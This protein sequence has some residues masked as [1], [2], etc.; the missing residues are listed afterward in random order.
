M[1]EDRKFIHVRVRAADHELF[2]A[3]ARKDRRKLSDWVRLTL[4]DAAL[5]S[6]PKPDQNQGPQ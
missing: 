1:S 5:E 3:A 6:V 4:T 2:E